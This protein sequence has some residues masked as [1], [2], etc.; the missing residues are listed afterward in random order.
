MKKERSVLSDTSIPDPLNVFVKKRGQISHVYGDEGK[1]NAKELLTA[2]MP[3]RNQLGCLPLITSSEKCNET[4]NKIKKISTNFNDNDRKINET[5]KKVL[6]DAEDRVEEEE[7]K[8]QSSTGSISELE[9]S[10][11]GK[12]LRK[13]FKLPLTMAIKEIVSKKPRDP[14]SYLGYWLLNYRRCQERRQLQLEKDNELRY[15]RSLIEE[16]MDTEEKVSIDWVGEEEEGRDGNFKYYETTRTSKHA[17][18]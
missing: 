4:T 6:N 7:S 17:D 1:V 13:Y 16:P 11:D 5:L 12:W 8:E 3:D 10:Y 9:L 14:V 15:L 2:L 18:F